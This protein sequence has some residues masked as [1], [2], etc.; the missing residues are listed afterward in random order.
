MHNSYEIH[1]FFTQRTDLL[2]N[3]TIL[4]TIHMKLNVFAVFARKFMLTNRISP[5]Y[6]T[7]TPTTPTIRTTPTPKPTPGTIHI[8]GLLL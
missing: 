5:R 7:D 3:S 8:L 1:T 2:A 6:N 4:Y